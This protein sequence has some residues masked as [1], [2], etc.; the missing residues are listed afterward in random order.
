MSVDKNNSVPEISVIIPTYNR[1][2]LLCRALRSALVQSFTDFECLIVNDGS[3][4]DTVQVLTEFTDVRMRVLF[5]ENR[6]VSAARNFAIKESKGK[7]IALLDSDDEWLPKK[8]EMQLAFMK[9]E[10]LDISQTNEIWVRNEKRVNQSK[11]YVKPEGM[12]FDKSL[13]TCL[14]SPSCAMFSKKFWDSVG[15]FDENMPACEDYD[16]WIRSGFKFPVGLLEDRL[17]IKYGGRPDQL[18][19][20]V[21]CF[22]LYRI[23]SIIKLL[24]SNELSLDELELAKVEL[25]RKVSYFVGGCR[26]RGKLEQAEKVEQMVKNVLEGQSVSPADILPDQIISV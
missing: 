4:D 5:Q 10:E 3:T 11:K 24:H 14:I 2:E 17:T 18:T 9:S 19:N 23:Y 12:F 6:G 16:L 21:G 15:P 20:S 13:E 26:K 7:Y 22:D 1:S 25:Q 8:L